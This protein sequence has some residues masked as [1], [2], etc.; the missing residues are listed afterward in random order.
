MSQALQ[1]QI[2]RDQY[3]ALEEQSGLRHQFLD[4]EVFAMTGGTLNHSRIARNIVSAVMNRRS[5]V[6]PCE[7]LN[8][9]MR[10]HTPSGLDAYPDVSVFCGS[11]DLSD[12]DRTL[13]NPVVIFEVLSPS[14][15]GF[16]PGDK[17]M[18]FRSIPGLS[19][20][21]LVDAEK[22]LVERFRRSADGVEWVLHEYRGLAE[23]LPLPVIEAE[24]P[25]GEIYRDISL[26]A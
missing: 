20:Y 18:H 6:R 17:F 12:N 10:I 14:T 23:I 11:P 25:L 15:E 26:P 3:L 21:V 9:D 4:G 8:S 19:D 22:V 7:P 5:R 2:T 13:H 1:N 16:D 24:L